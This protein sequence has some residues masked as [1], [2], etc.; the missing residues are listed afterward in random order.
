MENIAS[1]IKRLK[2]KLIPE[3][4]EDVSELV[5]LLTKMGKEYMVFGETIGLE[6]FNQYLSGERDSIIDWIINIEIAPESQTEE[7][8]L[9]PG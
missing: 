3:S 2:F 5:D 4:K 1:V 6:N 9:V 8:P 7:A